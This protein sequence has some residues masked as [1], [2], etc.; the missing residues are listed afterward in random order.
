MDDLLYRGTVRNLRRHIADAGF[1]SVTE[2]L[3]VSQLA[4]RNLARSLSSRVPQVPL[5]RDIFV[6]NMEY[7]L[8]T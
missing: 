2:N 5:V 3:S 7:V 8:T 4:T 6:T 1:K